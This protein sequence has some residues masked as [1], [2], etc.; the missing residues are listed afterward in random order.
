MRNDLGWRIISSDADQTINYEGNLV[1]NDTTLPLIVVTPGRSVLHLGLQPV[2]QRI[3]EI[4]DNVKDIHGQIERSIY[5][6]TSLGVNGNGYQQTP[7]NNFTDAVDDAEASNIFNLVLLSDATVDRQMRSF[8]FRG[9]GDPT[10]DVNGQDVN[11]SAFRDMR[12]DGSIVA[13]NGITA[14]RCTLLNNLSGLQGT[15]RLCGLNGDLVLATASTTLFVDCFSSIG[16]LNRPSIDVNGG[17]ANVSVRSQRGGLTVSGVSTAGA[18]VSVAMAEGKLTLDASN[19]DGTISIRGQSEF[20]DNSAGSVIDT[21]GFVDAVELNIAIQSLVG[22]ADVALND[23]SIEVKDKA[24]AVLRTLSMS[25]DGRVRR[26][27]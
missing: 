23:L 11:R 17:V 22:N 25:A 1:G 8:I 2:V 5:I 7:Y 15:F 18:G 9:I 27:V 4:G 19:T 13:A 14:D 26:I 20:T 24:L 16:G 6:D 21:E 10:L 3:E 12:L